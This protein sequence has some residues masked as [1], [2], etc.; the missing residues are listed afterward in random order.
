MSLE[1]P[2][3]KLDRAYCVF[4][5]LFPLSNWSFTSALTCIPHCHCFDGAGSDEELLQHWF[6]LATPPYTKRR[7]ITGAG[8][9]GGYSKLC[10]GNSA[11]WEVNCGCHTEANYYWFVLCWI[12]HAQFAY[13]P[14]KKPDYLHIQLLEIILPRDSVKEWPFFGVGS[15]NTERTLYLTGMLSV[16]SFNYVAYRNSV[17]LH[18]R[19]QIKTESTTARII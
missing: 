9:V 11:V 4:Y 5:V 1:T 2:A 12:C 17:C 8:R 13:K 7:N 15:S 3:G 19:L 10:W 6:A 14:V 18:F 16:Q